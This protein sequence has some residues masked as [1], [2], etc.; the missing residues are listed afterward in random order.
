MGKDEPCGKAGILPFSE[1]LARRIDTQR[2]IF[3]FGLIL[4]HGPFLEGL[5]YR[6]H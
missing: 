4:N 5:S 1:I 2:G 6:H 3:Q